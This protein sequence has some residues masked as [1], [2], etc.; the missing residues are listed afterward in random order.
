M[1]TAPSGKEK[2]T[3]AAQ[4]CRQNGP[5]ARNGLYIYWPDDLAYDAH[6][7]Q[8]PRRQPGC[9]A[10]A[11]GVGLPS[12]PLPEGPGLDRTTSGKRRIRP[13]AL[14]PRLSAGLPLS[15]TPTM[16]HR[17]DRSQSGGAENLPERCFRA[18]AR[19]AEIPGSLLLLPRYLSLNDLTLGHLH[20]K[21]PA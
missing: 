10:G 15:A 21:L 13:V 2:P 9:H 14:R 11:P 18:I 12:P 8:Q 16:P 5:L 7:P 19:Y 6:P 3:K 1:I 4:T 20:C 17:M